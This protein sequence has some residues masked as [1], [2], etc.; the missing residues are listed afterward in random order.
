[1]SFLLDSGRSGL[2][3]I[4]LTRHNRYPIPIQNI[5]IDEISYPLLKRYKLCT[6][7]ADGRLKKK[8]IF[9]SHSVSIIFTFRYIAAYRFDVK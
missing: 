6:Y 7:K 9:E 8:K 2:D 3:Y 1:M 5:L 4:A